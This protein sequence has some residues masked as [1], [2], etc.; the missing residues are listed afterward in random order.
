MKYLFIFF[1]LSIFSQN[2]SGWTSLRL[3]KARQNHVEI[4]WEA[5]AGATGYTVQIKLVPDYPTYYDVDDAANQNGFSTLP[6]D[7]VNATTSGG[8][9]VP[10][11][12]RTGTTAIVYG[13]QT[14]TRYRIRVIAIGATN[15]AFNTTYSYQLPVRTGLFP[16][17]TT[18]YEQTDWNTMRRATEPI[19]GDF[20][21]WNNYFGN[22]ERKITDRTRD[23]ND[24][25]ISVGY[26]KIQRTVRM[27]NGYEYMRPHEFGA[28][29]LVV[30][31]DDLSFDKKNHFWDVYVG[32]G[33]Q[34]ANDTIFYDTEGGAPQNTW[35]KYTNGVANTIYNAS[36]RV[37]A[38]S[39]GGITRTGETRVSWDERYFAPEEYN[40]GQDDAYVH[41]AIGVVYDMVTNS[42]V[43]TITS[44]NR[45]GNGQFEV[46]PKGDHAI[47]NNDEGSGV[48]AFMHVY[49]ISDGAYLGNAEGSTAG[50]TGANDYMGH[51][52][53]TIS[54]QGNCGI[55]GRKGSNV[56]FIP[57]EGPNAFE[58]LNMH[59][60]QTR[61]SEISH[62]GAQYYLHEGWAIMDN[63]VEGSAPPSSNLFSAYQNKI[64]S[65]Q[66]DESAHA[67]GQN[68]V[69]RFYAA[70]HT[71]GVKSVGSDRV[72]RPYAG[73]NMDMTIAFANLWLPSVNYG[74]S[75]NHPE[76]YAI[77]R[78]TLHGD[79]IPFTGS[80]PPPTQTKSSLF[81]W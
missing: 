12:C 53:L 7:C 55:I 4:A 52:D 71:D 13:L 44:P 64:W 29:R 3:T 27:A 34:Q 77:Q 70:H 37:G 6:S 10:T 11:I 48:G 51:A 31:M 45:L 67:R 72:I 66:V 32:I 2:N 35:V 56:I 1:S 74:N 68:S 24:R 28:N 20:A 42:V 81:G 40:V 65:M 79:E 9:N 75:N 22:R 36:P 25:G 30:R 23:G 16:T 73:A 17:E 43:R 59:V 54:I 5:I 38:A 63:S 49:R 58:N 18:V 15:N 60:A 50:G 8:S 47:F 76:A 61:S 39:N 69:V 26:P 33:I 14:N 57:Y 46:C 21:W 62:I 80:P 41:P 78:N 19:Q